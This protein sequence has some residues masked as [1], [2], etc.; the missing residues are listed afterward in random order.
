[1]VL[2]T[3]LKDRTLELTRMKRIARGLLSG[4]ALVAVSLAITGALYER[5]GRWREA[6]R[7]PQRGHLVQAG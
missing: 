3:N 2:F 4:L 6:Q 5:I 1:M 7:F